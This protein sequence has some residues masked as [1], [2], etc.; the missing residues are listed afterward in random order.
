L[1]SKDEVLEKFKIYKTEVEL[2]CETKIKCLRID[3]GGEYYD[4]RYFESTGIIHQVTAP[5][6]PQ[7]MVSRK[8]KSV[9]SWTW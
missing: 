2:K 1:H 4:P 7:K 8:E 9:H 5:Y 6:T 3:R